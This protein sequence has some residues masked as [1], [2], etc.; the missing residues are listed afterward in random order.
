MLNRD[1]PTAF[2]ILVKMRDKKVFEFLK[3]IQL[4]INLQKYLGKLLLIESQLTV[5]FILQ[6]YGKI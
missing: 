5:E 3:K 4:D 2:H 1:F 6:R